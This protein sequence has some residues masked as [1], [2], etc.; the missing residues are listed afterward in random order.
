M[1]RG[2]PKSATP[3]CGRKTCSGVLGTIGRIVGGLT[4]GLL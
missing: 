3:I 1:F 2:P 4:G